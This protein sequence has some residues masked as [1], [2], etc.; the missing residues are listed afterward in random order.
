MKFRERAIKSAVFHLL[1]IGSLCLLVYSNT[2]HVP[3]QW[4]EVNF[5][6]ENPII[7]DLGF[8]FEPSSAREFQYYY[9]LKMRYIGY[10]TFALN[11][12]A[13]GL[14]VTGY[15]VFNF[16]VHVMSAFL[17]Y[18]IAGLTFRTPY[19]SETEPRERGSKYIALLSGLLFACHPLQT[20]A[21][22]YIFQR[23][24]SLAAFFCLLSL[25]AYVRSRLS[26][27]AVTRT[28]LYGVSVASAVLA[29]KTKENAFTLPLMVAIYEFFFFSGHVRNRLLR[30]VPLGLTML[31]IPLS[32]VGIE[33]PVEEIMRSMNP[34]A[35][36]YQDL[37]PYVYFLTQLRVV[38][39]YFR[40]LFLPFGQN[41]LYDYPLYHSFLDYRVLLSFALLLT[42]FLFALF[43]L[44]RSRSGGARELRLIAFGI[45]WFFITLS[46]E[47]SIIPIQVVIDEYR[48]YL[49]SAGA[50]WAFTG[51]ATL[52]IGRIRNSAMKKAAA[53][54]LVIPLILYA[55]AAHAR[56]EVWQ[57]RVSLWQDVVK[58]SPMLHYAHDN[59]GVYYMEEGRFGDAEAEFRAALRLR[60]DHDKAHD[61]LG[62]LFAKQGRLEDSEREFKIS[63]QLNPDNAKAHHNLGLLYA[64]R[65]LYEEAEREFRAAIGLGDEIA[66][67]HIN[68]G[69]IF[70]VQGRFEE[71][72]RE[73]LIAIKLMPES[74]K[75]HYNLG[76]LYEAQ[77]RFEE[78]EIEFRT[79]LRVMP[80][81]EKAIKK[82]EELRQGR[83]R[84]GS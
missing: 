29:M 51:G 2:F 3:F 70:M 7:K 8:F 63:L 55:Y 23:L 4:D 73:H 74:A 49:P 46:V 18:W 36:G 65:G 5:I 33:R 35:V 24:A 15:H 1:L 21:V 48:V 57:S 45:L 19:F 47:S 52:L 50:F 12:A 78:A 11:F 84:T 69:I 58:K 66:S 54:A 13:D 64:R 67:A 22:T 68:L 38:V 28:A 82:L 72:E 59:L 6:G 39:T 71:S 80:G 25:A 81:Y 27:T 31:V 17:V 16:A 53:L 62:M 10:L 42:I 60:P 56:N 30:L 83:P 76:L 77:G 26:G 37:S 75:A 79:A 44:Y 61:N 43:L 20:E 41:L 34:M 32:I 40:L 9:A 14:D